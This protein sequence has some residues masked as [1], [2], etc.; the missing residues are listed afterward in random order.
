MTNAKKD[1]TSGEGDRIKRASFTSL[2]DTQDSTEQMFGGCRIVLD[3]E[4]RHFGIENQNLVDS[5]L[6]NFCMLVSLNSGES[7]FF[8]VGAPNEFLLLLMILYVQTS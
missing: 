1:K 6:V 2:D 8:S 4:V 5:Q 3:E 7:N